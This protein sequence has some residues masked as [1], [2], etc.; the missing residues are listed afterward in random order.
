MVT[1]TPK[2]P[3]TP[4]T[5]TKSPSKY[6]LRTPRSTAQVKQALN[7]ISLTYEIPPVISLLIRKIRHHYEDNSITLEIQ[8]KE[9][10]ILKHQNKELRPRKRKKVIFN[11]NAKFTKVPAIKKAHKAMLKIIQPRRTAIR[12][13]KIKQANLEHTFHLNLH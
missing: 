7:V 9:I 6:P 1:E 12:V 10:S 4:P 13:S 5:P 3:K 8:A 2:R 11:N